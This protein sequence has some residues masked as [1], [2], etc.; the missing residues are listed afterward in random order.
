MSLPREGEV[1]IMKDECDSYEKDTE[2][3]V[4]IW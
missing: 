3:G 4:L 1:V 2:R